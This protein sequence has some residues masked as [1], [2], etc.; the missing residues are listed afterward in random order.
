M[1]NKS[2]ILCFSFDLSEDIKQK[3]LLKLTRLNKYELKCLKWYFYVNSILLLKL[4]KHKMA[5]R[6]LEHLILIGESK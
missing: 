5:L 6:L 4:L 1:S 2:L 3:I